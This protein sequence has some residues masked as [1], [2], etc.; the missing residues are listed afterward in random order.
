MLLHGVTL[1]DGRRADVRL[2]AD[3][4]GDV[5]D[6]LPPVP[7]EDVRSLEGY[8]LLP[9]ACEPHAHLD[10][11]L[12]A[13]RVPNRTGD[14]LGAIEAW[15]AYRPHLTVDDIAS[16]AETAAR[17]LLANGIT[18]IRTHVDV[19]E[20]VGA[21][22]V[23]ALNKVKVALGELVHLEVVALVARPTTG[24]AGAGN[25]AALHEAM[26]AGADVVGGC[27][28]LDE[29][30][31][32]C[33]EFCLDLAG[34]LGKPL[35]LHMDE[36]LNPDMLVLPVMADRVRRSGFGQGATASHCVSL[37]MQPVD[38]QRSVAEQVAESGVAVVALPQTN[39]FLQGRQHPV[40]APRGL[41]ALRALLDAGATVAAGA[42][43]LQDPF[44]TMGRGDP[45]ETAALLVMAGHLLPDEAYAA[46]THGARSALRLEASHV[47]VEPGDPADLVA[48]P[49]PSLRAA[50]AD[51]PLGRIVWRA[52]KV[53]SGTGG[54][55]R[56][57]T[58]DS[59]RSQRARAEGDL[60]FWRP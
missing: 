50:M 9:S 36:T 4:V 34:E 16:R 38:I 53:L 55:Q 48:L 25:R 57:E 11:A 1:A 43:N 10:K 14:L 6:C 18:A 47:V 56:L 35:D 23:E 15:T 31:V 41:T 17:R 45:M 52:G 7:G 30:P 2:Q 58:E 42:D 59:Q 60:G 29:D 37:G 46:V 22:G 21:R 40:A 54:P 8:V 3:R 28:H 32:G 20:D 51:A 49:S 5:A 13:D 19:A 33:L 27:P 44:N 39:L 12:T 26:A 24:P